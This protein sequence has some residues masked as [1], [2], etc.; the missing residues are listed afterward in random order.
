GVVR[1]RERRGARARHLAGDARGLPCALRRLVGGA[2]YRVSRPRY[3]LRPR[4]HRAAPRCRGARRPAQGRGSSVT[5][6]AP[7][8]LAALVVPVV[9]YVIHWLFGSRRR[10][11]VPALFLWSDLPQARTGRSRRH[12]PPFTWLLL[13]QLLAAALAAVAL[14]RP[15]GPLEPPR[16]L[17]LVFDASASMQATDISPT[18]FEAA[19][20]RALERL[21]VLT[22]SDLVS[23]VRAGRE[24]TLIT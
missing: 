19:R 11:R 2:G 18:R 10:V 23:V 1:L 13:L 4:G 22:A 12:I 6:L 7:M 24:G 17:A 9:I 21:N 5:L 3:P 8:A 14:A 15:V 16:H 20:A